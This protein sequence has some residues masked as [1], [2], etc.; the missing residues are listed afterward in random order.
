MSGWLNYL[1]VAQ[2]Y[3]AVQIFQ[4][5]LLRVLRLAQLLYQVRLHALQLTHF[6]LHCVDL[7]LSSLLSEFIL[8]LHFLLHLSLGDGFVV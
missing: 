4:C 7:F 5:Y 3:D 6:T 2:L 8:P 1:L